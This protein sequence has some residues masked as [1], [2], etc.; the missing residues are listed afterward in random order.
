[1][2]NKLLGKL[3]ALATALAGFATS[4]NAAWEV[5]MPRGVTAV[6]NEVYGLHML[7]FWVCVAIAVVV[8]GAMIVS[9]VKHRTSVGVAPAKFT[10]RPRS[11]GPLC[12][13]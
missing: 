10:H 12:R 8:F 4:A 11:C 9:L 7:I 6:S 3:A 1:M 5:N 13:A 2:S